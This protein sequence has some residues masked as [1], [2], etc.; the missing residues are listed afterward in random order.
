MLPILVPIAII[1]LVS[2]LMYKHAQDSEETSAQ[3]HR[4]T[5]VYV[6]ITLAAGGLAYRTMS[7]TALVRPTTSGQGLNNAPCTRPS[8]KYELRK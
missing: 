5:W 1:S 4:F 6:L 8:C 2:W 3:R 7:S